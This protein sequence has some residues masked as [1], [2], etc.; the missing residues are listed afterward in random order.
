MPGST[1][2]LVVFV[3]GVVDACTARADVARMV[4]VG[5]AAGDTANGA[6]VEDC[7]AAGVVGAAGAA[8]VALCQE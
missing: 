8:C 7:D 4:G 3:T 6:G 1:I 2:P 5:V